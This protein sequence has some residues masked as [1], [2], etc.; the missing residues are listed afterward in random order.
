MSK[1]LFLVIFKLTFHIIF[2][3][4]ITSKWEMQDLIQL[5]FKLNR[6]LCFIIID[7]FTETYTISWLTP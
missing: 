2:G 4:N 1:N 7:D 5:V 3:E 6:Y